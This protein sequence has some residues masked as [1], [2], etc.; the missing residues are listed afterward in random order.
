MD[1]MASSLAGTTSAL[2]LDT[3]TLARRLVPLPAGSAVLVLDSGIPRALAESGYNQRRAECE[4]AARL[5]GVPTL[6]D[7]RDVSQADT[8]PE[9]LR[10]RVRHVVSENDQGVAR[11]RLLECAG[12]WHLDECITRKPS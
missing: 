12:V 10:R 6:R 7:V 11:G 9:P 8:L 1:Q 4:E 3:Q 5:L 2:F